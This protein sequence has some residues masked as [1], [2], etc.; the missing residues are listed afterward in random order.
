MGNKWSIEKRKELHQARIDH[1]L[2]QSMKHLSQITG[3][4]V[5]EHTQLAIKD[6]R[7]KNQSILDGYYLEMSGGNR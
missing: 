6:Y 4:S 2:K 3:Q 7:D 5:S 1:D